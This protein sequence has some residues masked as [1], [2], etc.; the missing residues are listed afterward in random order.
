MQKKYFIVSTKQCVKVWD[1]V[2]TFSKK[3]QIF[4]QFDSKDSMEYCLNCTFLRVAPLLLYV[5]TFISTHKTYPQIM[6]FSSSCLEI[7]IF[8]VKTLICLCEQIKLL[9]IDSCYSVLGNKQY[10]LS[11][12]FF[13]SS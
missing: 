13:L 11:I 10:W 7:S 1:T 6:P 9:K 2:F 8:Y 3:P 4:Q 12:V 5:F